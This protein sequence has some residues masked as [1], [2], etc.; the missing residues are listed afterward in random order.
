MTQKSCT[1]VQ[2]LEANVASTNTFFSKSQTV[3]G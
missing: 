2:E 3:L 1:M